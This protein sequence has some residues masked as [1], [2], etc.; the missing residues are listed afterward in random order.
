[1]PPPLPHLGDLGTPGA[2]ADARDACRAR[3]HATA[4]FVAVVLLAQNID[5]PC[6]TPAHV[7]SQTGD[8]EYLDKILAKDR[9]AADAM[10][11]CGSQIRP[12][13]L[14]ANGGHTEIVLQLMLAGAKAD[15]AHSDNGVTPLMA[16]AAAGHTDV[17]RL[18]VT[19]RISIDQA[20]ARNWTALTVSSIAPS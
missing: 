14:A 5:N 10:D 18:L 9:A 6:W 3:M 2:L 13:M 15:S 12:L 20:E 11:T 17:V 7:A 1:V 19:K 4:A 16:A 8:V